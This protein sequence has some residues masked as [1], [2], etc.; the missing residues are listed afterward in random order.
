MDKNQSVN[1]A[2]ICAS[3]SSTCDWFNLFTSNTLLL[4]HVQV[5]EENQNPTPGSLSI[6]LE[7]ASPFFTMSCVEIGVCHSSQHVLKEIH[8]F[9][10][11]LLSC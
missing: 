1:N 7:I 10:F 4:L 5:F 11:K 2:Y 6:K 9:L 3:K 8:H